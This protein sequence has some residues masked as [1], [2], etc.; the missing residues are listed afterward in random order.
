MIWVWPEGQTPG[1]PYNQAMPVCGSCSTENPDIAF[2]IENKVREA[3]GIP[4]LPA[5]EAKE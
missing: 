2:E 4:L 5:N 1:R 3:M